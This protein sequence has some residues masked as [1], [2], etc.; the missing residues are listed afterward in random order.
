VAFVRGLFILRHL[1]K[2]VKEID[3]CYKRGEMERC[4]FICSVCS[5]A[6]KKKVI[7]LVGELSLP[8]HSAIT[9]RSVVVIAH[10]SAPQPTPP[11]RDSVTRRE[12]QSA[13]FDPQGVKQ[14]NSAPAYIVNT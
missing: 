1:Y 2:S 5:N 11:G 13:G 10:I 12:S 14:D 3:T 7:L 9:P 8:A 4:V 6:S